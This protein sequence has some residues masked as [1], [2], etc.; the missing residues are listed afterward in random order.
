MDNYLLNNSNIIENKSYMFIDEYINSTKT[1]QLPSS[2]NTIIIN[3]FDIDD[4][5]V[6]DTFIIT[7]SSYSV[8]NNKK[9]RLISKGTDFDEDHKMTFEKIGDDWIRYTS[10]WYGTYYHSGSATF[11][12]KKSSFTSQLLFNNQYLYEGTEKNIYGDIPNLIF[13]DLYN[14]SIKRLTNPNRILIKYIPSNTLSPLSDIIQS[15]NPNHYSIEGLYKIVDSNTD[16]DNKLL[17][18]YNYDFNTDNIN[19]QI[20][21]NNNA[22]ISTTNGNLDTTFDTPILADKIR[23]NVLEWNSFI[24]LRYDVY[25]SDTIDG[26]YQLNNT[27][28]IDRYYSSV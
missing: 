22:D 18:L 14:I 7:N 3:N 17:K 16:Y 15:F 5:N 28:E 23:L 13:S 4:F 26:T 20:T 12:I 27:P 19:L 6:N 10:Y 25:T 24:S 9:I 8:F 1:F 11:N 21:I 2:P